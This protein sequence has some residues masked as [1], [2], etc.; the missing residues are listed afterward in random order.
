MSTDVSNNSE[1][2]ALRL[3]YIFSVRVVEVPDV[4][5][6]HAFEIGSTQ[7]QETEKNWPKGFHN[8]PPKEREEYGSNNHTTKLRHK[9]RTVDIEFIY[10]RVLRIMASSQNNTSIVKLCMH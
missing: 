1:H 2:T 10:A 9:H 4:N 5:V 8:E 3:V 7:C 6:D